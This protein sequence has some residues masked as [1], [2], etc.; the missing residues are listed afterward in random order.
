MDL[1]DG[2][3]VEEVVAALSPFFAENLVDP[4]DPKLMASAGARSR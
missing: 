3:R 4:L 1:Y 2:P